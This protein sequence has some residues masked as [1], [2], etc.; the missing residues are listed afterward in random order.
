[1][2]G[3]S[4]VARAERGSA[5]AEFAVLIPAVCLVLALCLSALQLATSQ[6]QVHD[7]AALAARTAGRGGDPTAVVSTMIPGASIHSERRGNLLCVHVD[8][9][10]API[11]SLLGFSKITATSCA[12]AGGN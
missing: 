8:T 1:M 4:R 5:T 3:L 9:A 11:A 10:S 6:L 7:A 2:R 12:L